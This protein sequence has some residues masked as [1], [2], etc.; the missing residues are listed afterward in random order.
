MDYY[1]ILDFCAFDVDQSSAMAEEFKC[2]WDVI[3][4]ALTEVGLERMESQ[5]H[6]QKGRRLFSE[7]GC[8]GA[9][10]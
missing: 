1:E 2:P 8:E 3:E 9:R 4:E 7:G 5:P 10:S 6:S